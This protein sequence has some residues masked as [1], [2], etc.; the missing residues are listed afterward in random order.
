MRRLSVAFMLASSNLETAKHRL[1]G[2]GDDQ[3][4][5]NLTETLAAFRQECADLPLPR[6]FFSQVEHVREQSG[7]DVV[8]D[9]VLIALTHQLQHSLYNELAEHL[10]F[11]VSRDRKWIY[12]DPKKWFGEAALI[13]FSGT[14]RDVRDACQSF[15]LDQW[16]ATVFHSMR[17]LERGLLELARLVGLDPVDL[18][19]ENWKNITDQIER[20]IRDMESLPKSAAKSSDLQFLSGAAAQFRYFKDA[21]RNHVSHA[22]ESYDEQE[23]RIVLEHVRDFMAHLASRPLAP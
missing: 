15:A 9:V 1:A 2:M 8:P 16:T 12:L 3:A 18:A 4:R 17:I 22:R 6:A 21:W 7:L 11:S 13:R 10:F 5:A 19:L 14:W 23:A 20:N